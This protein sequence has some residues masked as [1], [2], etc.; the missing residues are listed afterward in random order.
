MGSGTINP[1]TE[2]I[3]ATTSWTEGWAWCAILQLK[4]VATRWGASVYP[5]SIQYPAWEAFC[6]SLKK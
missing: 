4:E 3:V 6:T 1:M 2:T 5:N